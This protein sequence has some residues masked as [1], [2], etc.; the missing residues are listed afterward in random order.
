MIIFY[1]RHGM[2]VD[3]IQKKISFQQIKWPEKYMNFSTQKRNK[4]K[5]TFKK[6]SINYLLTHFVEK[7]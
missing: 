3:K 7:Q 2:I 5:M 6:T 4:A 1:I